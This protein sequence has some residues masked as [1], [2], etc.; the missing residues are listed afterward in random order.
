MRQSRRADLIVALAAAAFSLSLSE[1]TAQG[2]VPSPDHPIRVTLVGSTVN[3]PSVSNIYYLAATTGGFFKKNGIDLEMQQSTGS[4]TSLAA[5]MSGKAQF[6][7]INMIVLANAAAE[8]IAAK[9][10]VTG[11]FD[12]PGILLARP[13]LTSIQDLEGRLMGISAIGASE[14]NVPRGYLSKHGVDVDKIKWAPTG[15]EHN[16]VQALVSG[17]VDA[18]WMHIAESLSIFQRVPDIKVLVDSAAFSKET[19][20]TGGIV[21]VTDAYAKAN[22]R[23]V[24]AFTEAV[25]EANRKLYQE[26]SFFDQVVEAW[27]PNV[28]SSEQKD[29]LYKALSPSWGVNGGLMTS[30]L[31]GTL[32]TWKTVVNPQKAVNPY[33]SR[34]ADLM[35]TTFAQRALDQLGVFDGALDTAPWY[36]GKADLKAPALGR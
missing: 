19:P 26:R 20:S 27:M 17:R 1:A 32:D 31:E 21:V 35:D 22:P 25:I 3:P 16:T 30:V 6:A 29:I 24:A 7:S 9:L 23:V 14:Y 10:V 33:F 12:T 5:V 18:A 8:G 2:F 4:P 15:S 36:R 11:N 13:T 34:S 28:Y